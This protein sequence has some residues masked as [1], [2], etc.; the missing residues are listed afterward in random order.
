MGTRQ[1]DL[2][3]VAIPVAKKLVQ[4]YGE[5][6]RIVSGAILAFDWMPPEYQKAFMA[7]AGGAEVDLP[8]P[9]EEHLREYLKRAVALAQM[10]PSKSEPG[11]PAKPSKGK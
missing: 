10:L 1:D 8:T 3:V 9:S 6:K 11:R 5:W 7:R 4:D 2:E